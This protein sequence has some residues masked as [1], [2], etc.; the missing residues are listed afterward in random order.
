MTLQRVFTFA[1][2]AIQTFISFASTV[3]D[4]FT[5]PS[6]QL[7][8]MASDALPEWADILMTPLQWLLEAV[9]PADGTLFDFMLGAGLVMIVFFALGKFFWT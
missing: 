8:Q 3:I 7:L 6:G 4:V 2:G 5:M 1:Q 9:L